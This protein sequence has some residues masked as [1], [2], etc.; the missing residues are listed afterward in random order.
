[1]EGPAAPQERRFSAEYVYAVLLAAVLL[2][3]YV[4]TLP[5]GL[6]PY[7]DAGE[8][9]SAA[10]TLGVAHQ[11]GY[12]LYIISAKLFSLLPLGNPA[13]LLNL[14]SAAAAFAGVLVFWRLAASVFP[15]PAA[16]FAALCLAFNF[17]LRT[18]GAV[19]E[20]YALHF[21]LAALLLLAASAP[22]RCAVFLTA[23]LLGLGMANRMDLLLCA[24]AL[25]LLL[26]PRLMAGGWGGLLKA[27]GFFTLGFSLYLYLPFRSSGWPLFDWSH[28]AGAAAFFAVITRKSYGS[29]LDLISL[30]YST[31][32]L[33]WPNLKY[34]AAHLAR[35]FSVAL[36]FAA[37]GAWAEWRANRGR[38]LAFAALLIFPGPV[39][40]FLANM[41]PNPHALAIVEPYYLLPDLAVAF[42]AAAGLCWAARAYPKAAPGVL[43][44]ALAAA[45]LV[46]LANAYGT[47]RRNLFVAQD[48][49][50]DVLRGVPPGSVLVAKKDVQLFSLWY[51]QAVKKLR[52]DVQVV[53][54]GLSG[55]GWYKASKARYNPSLALR[56]LNSGTETDWKEFRDANPGRLYATMDVELPGKTPA[57]ARG[58][59]SEIFPAAAPAGPDP[60]AFYSYGRLGRPYR[61]F[62]DRDLGTSYAQALVGS[63]AARSGSL[64]PLD[65]FRLRLA[66][67]FDGEIPDAPL[68]EGFYHSSRS[69]WPAAK[70]CFLASV[71]VYDRL[72]ELSLEYHSLPSL[73][74][75]LT[76]ASAYAWLNYGVTLEK[77]GDRAG[78]ERAY[79]AALA[80][81]P[82]MADAHYNL[83]I[84]Y[85]NRDWARVRYELEQT[86]RLNPGH[87]RAAAYLAQMR[88]R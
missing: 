81:N 8:M 66:A 69:D 60:W 64:T 59:V 33:F 58:L 3:L 31:G 48:Y 45:G 13:W 54:Q 25:L 1:M 9:A 29:T 50:S 84:L 70:A 39:F 32:E 88:G 23:F 2:P 30:N 4:C 85:W 62:F 16:F 80:A 7:R 38:F 61:D 5:P 67:V 65:V 73:K 27:I 46:F 82:A 57:A 56:N 11:P 76:A 41:P 19:P 86:V 53:A 79:S 78:A 28:P 44:A 63:A 12:P 21:L 6:P 14:F 24:P 22:W 43:L 72:L 37:V 36:A 75:G 77:T 51:L 47:N 68:Y 10:W 52:P 35:N 87:S 17:T 34:Y 18:V 40:L 55:A 15:G 83:A 49:A 74:Q 20:M 26:R 71:R 42:W